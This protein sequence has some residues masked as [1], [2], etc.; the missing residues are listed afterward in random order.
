LAGIPQVRIQLF[1]GL[2]ESRKSESNCFPVCG[3]PA[4]QNPTVFRFAGFPQVRIQLFFDLRESRKSESNCFPVC[5][6][7]RALRGIPRALRGIPRALWGIPRA[8]LESRKSENRRAI[9]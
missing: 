6:I 7:P 1:S 5:G 8:L 4:S 3:N 2:R 9:I